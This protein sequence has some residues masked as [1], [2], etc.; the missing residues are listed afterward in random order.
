MLK[1]K[2]ILLDMDGTIAYTDDMIIHTMLDL[3][4]LYNPSGKK[5]IEE[6]LYF[7]GPPLKVT[8][9]KEFPNQDYKF[10]YNEFIR[11]SGPYY[12]QYVKAFPHE[13]ETLTKLKSAGYHLAVVT[14]KGTEKAHYV[15]RLIGIN[16]LIDFVIGSDDVIN[17]KP[18]P[19]GLNKAMDK[20]GVAPQ[21]TLYMG[22]NDIDY[23]T[24]SNAHIDTLIV[25]WG[26]RTLTVLDKAKYVASSYEEIEK[27]LL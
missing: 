21:E 7:S 8:L 26:P 24:A 12:D 25:N 5:S 16:H 18:H 1:Y 27:I 13:I 17:T 20:L 22:D 6:I 10:M 14:N 11:I 15:L 4:D 23:E 2:A 3:Y 9:P 19:E